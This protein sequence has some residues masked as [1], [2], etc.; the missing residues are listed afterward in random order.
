M[1]LETIRLENF[2]CYQDLEITLHENMTVLVA[3]NGQGKTAILDAI[4]IA[5]W[6]FVS[7]FDL[8]KT[9]SGS[10]STITIDDV[11]IVKFHEQMARQLPT[12]ITAT[13]RYDGGK[14]TWER[15]RDSEAERSKTKD[16]DG[17]KRLKINAKKLQEQVRDLAAPKKTLPVF[18]YYGTG[19]LWNEKRFM[20]TNKSTTEEKNSGIRTFAYRDCLDPASSFKQFQDWFASGYKK[21][22]EYKIRQ[23]ED[24]AT[25]IDVPSDLSLP[26]KVVQDVVDEVLKPVEWGKLRYSEKYGKSLVLED[27]KEI[28]IK[29]NKL[30]DGIKNMVAMT[31]DIAYRCVLLNGHLEDQ[32]A[33]RS[34]GIVLIDEIDMHLHPKW[35]KTVVES[36]CKSFPE[37][38]FVVTTHSPQ[39]LSTVQAESIRIISNTFDDDV[40]AGHVVSTARPAQSQTRGVASADVMAEIQCVDPVPDIEETRW[41]NRY[42]E[43]IDQGLHDGNEGK[44]LEGKIISHF[45]KNHPKWLE[46]KRLIRFEEMKLKLRNRLNKDNA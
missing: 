9:F 30:S 33:K 4:R 5:L 22:L 31:A 15:Y 36:L 3:D 11:R 16:D 24:G 8:A 12:S 23:L 7:Q 35:Q 45:G 19:R 39:V 28:T 41:V 2:R 29:I 20:D 38:Q 37:I 27:S 44:D 43:L 14:L 42:V 25:V 1:K 26:I 21:I 34:P 13:G 17:A 40:V 46:C 6:S 18:G 32:A 10:A